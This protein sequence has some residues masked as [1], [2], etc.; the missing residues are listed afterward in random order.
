MA[1]EFYIQKQ[2]GTYAETLEAFGIANL[3]NEILSRTNQQGYKIT[4]KDK[5]QG[6]YLVETNIDITDSLIQNLTYFQ[7]IKFIKKVVTT[8]I[9][10]GINDYF[11]YPKN[12]AIQDEY[13]ERYKQI[14]RIKSEEEKKSARKAL[15][16]EK[17]SEYG[18][19]IDAEY[20][21]YREICKN[22]YESFLKAFNN[23]HSNQTNFKN[24]I[25][26]ILNFYAEGTFLTKRIDLVD[27]SPT[28]HSIFNPTCGKGLNKDKA[29]GPS[30]GPI[31][32]NWIS[33]TMKISGAYKFMICQY[34]KVGSGTDFKIYVPEFNVIGFSE[35]QN[36]TF[37]FKKYLR[38]NSPIK[39]DIMNS[40]DFV[41]SFIKHTPEYRGK[42]NK[43]IKGFH[44]VY[45]KKLG[46]PTKPGTVTN[47]GFINVPNFVDIPDS[48][49][50]QEWI[51]ILEDQRNLIS[52]IKEQ[53]D[54]IQGLQEYRN[55]IGS[56]GASALEYF[57]GFSY[58]YA[59][60]LMQQ[61]AK[62][63]RFVRTFKIEY[64]TKFYINMD[65][66]ELNL[67][68]IIQNE[69]FQA[70]AKAIRKSTVTL[71]YIPKDQR[72]FEIR[73]GLAQQLQN[74]A[75]SKEDLAT[76]IGE[77]IGTY[78]AETARNVEKN[79]GK[80]F[81]ANVKDDE[82]IKFYCLL[83]NNSPRL[84]GAL[85]ASYGFALNKKE[86]KEGEEIDNEEIEQEEN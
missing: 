72:K 69:G 79:G 66:K 50:G 75:K 57:S 6:Y 86:V 23:I 61:L 11:D 8:E 38:Q 68:E 77:F 1:K 29:S 15:N 9:P 30:V 36:L 41:I 53:G 7:V 40:C 32:S 42:V 39:L 25:A 80:A 13:N 48:E 84:V 51:E 43:T 14:E 64:L 63:N 26:H 21:V 24:V 76:F 60:Y 78:N 19:K 20:N 54:A 17:V 12:K 56:V 55:F 65:T 2:S 71:Q 5:E 3:L 58:W 31:K 47:I 83:D 70:V 44:S 59:G 37:E 73:Y 81:R 4:M 34:T 22:P 74:K 45:Q 16:I 28:A 85:L 67:C 27:K 10:Q 52:N 33:E 82:L 35:A 46:G 62:G 18:L 49:Q